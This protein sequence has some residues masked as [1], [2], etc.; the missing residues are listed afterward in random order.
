[1]SPIVDDVGLLVN[2]ITGETTIVLPVVESEVKVIVCTAELPFV[3]ATGVRFEV[4][5][6][7]FTLVDPTSV[8]VA[9]AGAAT[10]PRPKAELQQAQCA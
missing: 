9:F 4:I 3:P 1:V 7:L 5:V 10:T 2:L 6:M 8:R